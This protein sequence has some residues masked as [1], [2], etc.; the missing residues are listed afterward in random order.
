M[1]VLLLLIY[2]DGSEVGF[3]MREADL[4]RH[5]TNPED[6]DVPAVIPPAEPAKET[7]PASKDEVKEKPAERAA[8]IEF[9]SEN[10]I[11]LT[12]ALNLLKGIKVT[13]TKPGVVPEPVVSAPAK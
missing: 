7:A 5:L 6:S 11:Q 12:Q 10:D 2:E 4:T 9:G 13:P 1:A 3:N 8:P